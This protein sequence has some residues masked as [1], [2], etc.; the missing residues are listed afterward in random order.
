MLTLTY[1]TLAVL[2]C[3]YV[4]VSAFLGHLGDFSGSDGGHGGDGGHDVGHDAAHPGAHG[5]NSYG[6]VKTGHGKVSASEGEG[7]TFHFPFFSPLALATLMASLGA[8]GLIALHGFKVSDGTSLLLALP[9][10]LATVYAVSYVSWRITSS[11]EA[12]SMIRTADLIGA[13]AEVTTPIP[14][15]GPGE[16]LAMVRGQRFASSARERGGQEVARGAAVRVVGMVGSIL[17]VELESSRK[18]S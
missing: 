17:L 16:V 8:Y 18:E 2:G 11:S 7:A 3:G 4:I 12:S 1:L 9:V 15:G 5:S 6:V 10:A 13:L 14:A